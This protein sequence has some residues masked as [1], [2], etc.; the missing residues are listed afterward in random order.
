[1]FQILCHRPIDI[2]QLKRNRHRLPTHNKSGAKAWRAQ[3]QSAENLNCKAFDGT[4][5]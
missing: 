5:F 3:D 2:C 4:E 1:M